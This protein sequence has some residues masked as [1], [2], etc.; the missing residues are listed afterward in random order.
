MQKTVFCRPQER[1]DYKGFITNFLEAFGQKGK[2]NIVKGVIH[3][4]ESIQNNVAVRELREGLT[5]AHKISF[6]LIRYCKDAEWVGPDS[7]FF[8]M[9]K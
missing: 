4:V 6:G 9:S 8:F 7:I 2:A 3:A 1:N 5:G